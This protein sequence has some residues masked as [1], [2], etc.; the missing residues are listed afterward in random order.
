MSEVDSS[1]LR[2][3][4]IILILIHGN[5]SPL[6][7][8]G[9]GSFSVST[10]FGFSISGV[11]SHFP[12]LQ[13]VLLTERTCLCLFI[14]IGKIGREFKADKKIGVKNW[15]RILEVTQMPLVSPVGSV[16]AS[17]CGRGVRWTPAPQIPIS[18][19]GCTGNCKL[20]SN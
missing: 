16:G 20:G 7:D 10:K 17:A 8:Y 3:S 19:F 1:H 18:T 14:N 13:S 5:Q 15:M 2:S 4:L 11:R 6:L 9:Y 12:F